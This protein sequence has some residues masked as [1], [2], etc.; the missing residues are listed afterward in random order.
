MKDNFKKARQSLRNKGITS[1]IIAVN[2]CMY[3]KDS[4]PFKEDVDT[5]KTYL[6]Y[7]GQEFWEFISED[8]N[9]YQEIIVP[10]G[11]EAKKKDEI[12]KS[13]LDAKVNEMTFEFIQYFTTNGRIDWI[14]LFDYVSKKGDVKL[15]AISQQMTL[16]LEDRDADLEE[17]LDLADA[18]DVEE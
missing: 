11:E 7:A 1:N 5:D 13:T 8:A 2:S 14:K 6:K 4:S 9:L 16:E 18:L 15:E 17:T 10:I 3:G 12:F